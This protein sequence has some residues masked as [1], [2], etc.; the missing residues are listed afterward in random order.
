MR[1]LFTLSSTNQQINKELNSDKNIDYNLE[2][3]SHSRTSYQ[4]DNLS[5]QKNY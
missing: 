2:H 4:S 5:K 1:R 3:D